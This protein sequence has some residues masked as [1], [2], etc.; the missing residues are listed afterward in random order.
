MWNYFSYDTGEFPNTNKMEISYSEG[1]NGMYLA[2][3]LN[4]FS[5]CMVIQ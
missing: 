5:S 1:A 4:V 3:S 2:T